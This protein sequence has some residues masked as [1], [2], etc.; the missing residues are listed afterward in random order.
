[1]R[2]TDKQ[3]RN[4]PS[5]V[6]LKQVFELTQMNKESA[7]IHSRDKVQ[8]RQQHFS[9]VRSSHFRKAFYDIREVFL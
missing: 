2:F 6:L 7:L 5:P 1:M 4:E 9:L 8:L 3:T